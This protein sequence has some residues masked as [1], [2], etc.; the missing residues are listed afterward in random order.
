MDGIKLFKFRVVLIFWFWWRGCLKNLS[1]HVWPTPFLTFLKSFLEGLP[2]IGRDGVGVILPHMLLL[3]LPK[4]VTI[5]EKWKLPA[6]ARIVISFITLDRFLAARGRRRAIVGGGKIF[7][8]LDK[9][10][11]RRTK[12]ER[13]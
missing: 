13:K 11:G 5:A 3:S 12:E 4:V 7:P 2:F 1:G 6:T 10:G 9:K 8:K